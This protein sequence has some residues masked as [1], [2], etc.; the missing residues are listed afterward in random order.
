MFKRKI[1]TKIK[2]IIEVFLAIIAYFIICI[3]LKE[4]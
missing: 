1:E 4:E 3:F 2:E